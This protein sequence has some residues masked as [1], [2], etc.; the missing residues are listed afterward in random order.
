M[1]RASF[2][3]D[4]AAT[5]PAAA[6]PP[7]A[8]ASRADS[9]LALTELERLALANN[10]AVR[11][12]REEAEAAWQKTRSVD[13]LPDPSLG[14]NFFIPPMNFEPER[15]VGE[16]QFMQMLPWLGRLRTEARRACLEAMV[17][18][19]LYQAERLRV[20]AEVRTAWCQLYVWTRQGETLLAEKTQLES[21]IEAT[22]R[23]VSTG[24][25]QP[26]DVLLATLELS[27]LQ[28]QLIQVRRQAVAAT[29]ELNRLL[30]RDS[31]TPVPP[32][33]EIPSNLPDWNPSMLREAART[34]QPEWNAAR[35][36]TAATR[37]GIEVARLRRRPELTLG[38][39]WV[40][41]DA[42][43]AT[44]PAAGRD[45]LSLG[46]ST[47][48][49]IDRR[50]YDAL[51]SEAAREHFAAHAQEDEVAIRINALLR[52]LWEQARAQH[53]TLLLYRTSSLPQARQTF[54]ADLNSLATN[55]VTFERV[56]QDWRT[57]LKLET[58][59][60]RAVGDLGMTLARI[61][62]TVGDDLGD[63]GG[64]P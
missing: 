48:L 27:S 34:F 9:D 62:Q 38:V 21:L 3:S 64:P 46:V 16:V 19:N 20:L 1:Q 25:A 39:G 36:K 35:L 56:I 31:E 33:A 2:E 52:D 6:D 45:N 57:L 5:G 14:A 30:G 10:P 40:V 47:T 61:R 22:S 8:S 50:K 17:A 53:E 29:V 51:A 15:Q 41:M 32:P 28:E 55:A 54:Q 37:W 58:S 7:P 24:N 42:P 43:G 18:E 13:R 49:P 26:G 59:Y 12:M 11:R 44:M 63:S 4:D 60:H 23:R